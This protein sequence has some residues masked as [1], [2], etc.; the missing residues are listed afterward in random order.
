MTIDFVQTPYSSIEHQA[1]GSLGGSC[2]DPTLWCLP[3]SI[4]FGTA[5]VTLA[6][7]TT[8]LSSSP[9]RLDGSAALTLQNKN[10]AAVDQTLSPPPTTEQTCAPATASNVTMHFVVTH[11]PNP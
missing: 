2:V 9:P 5:M 3:S 10:A 1:W 8:S 6:V 11:M 4:L 7:V